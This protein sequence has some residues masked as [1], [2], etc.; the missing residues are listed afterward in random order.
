MRTSIHVN[1]YLYSQ[2]NAENAKGVREPL[3]LKQIVKK[4]N[5]FYGQKEKIRTIP[6]IIVKNLISIIN[7]TM[8]TEGII[9]KNLI[10][11]LTL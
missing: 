3:R 9:N 2:L 11:S 8:V 5:T 6:S 7:M 10:S 4:Q 1:N